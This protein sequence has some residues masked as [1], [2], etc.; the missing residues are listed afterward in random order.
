MQYL[1]MERKRLGITRGEKVGIMHQGGVFFFFSLSTNENKK[2]L[3]TVVKDSVS[4]V[5]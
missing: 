3:Y 4:M 5:R 2:K 1:E